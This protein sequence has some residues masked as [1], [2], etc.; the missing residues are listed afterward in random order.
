[1]ETARDKAIRLLLDLMD[2]AAPTREDA[3]A[4]IDAILEA[5]RAPESA[6]TRAVSEAQANDPRR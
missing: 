2:T 6:H 1:M 3:T 4:I 5:A